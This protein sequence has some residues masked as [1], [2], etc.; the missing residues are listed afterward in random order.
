M[1]TFRKTRRLKNQIKLLE[2]SKAVSF[3][4]IFFLLFSTSGGILPVILDL[5]IVLDFVLGALD[6]ELDAIA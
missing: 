1:N 2:T 3:N 5:R 6:L 4:F